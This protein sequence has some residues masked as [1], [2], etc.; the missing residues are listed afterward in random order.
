MPRYID[1]DAFEKEFCENCS[2]TFACVSCAV[3]ATLARVRKIPTADVGR[4][5]ERGT[6][7]NETSYTCSECN[8]HFITD[9]G[10]P[11]EI[12]WNY[13]PNC[14]KIMRHDLGNTNES[15]VFTNNDE[16]D[17]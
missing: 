6:E 2:Y 12:L 17:G 13:C 14:G 16:K 15:E 3:C 4:W 10:K 8:A 11:S 9:D 7:W 5:I 1:A